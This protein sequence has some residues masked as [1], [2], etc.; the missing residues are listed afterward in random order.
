MHSQGMAFFMVLRRISSPTKNAR[1]SKI[2][3]HTRV[4]KLI[5]IAR[6]RGK[7]AD[8]SSV[9][10]PSLTPSPPGASS[11]MKPVIQDSV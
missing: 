7:M 2:V 4:I 11:T 8:R 3:I 10:I 6:G 5:A 9:I 1:T